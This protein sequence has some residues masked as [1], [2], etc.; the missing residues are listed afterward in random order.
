MFKNYS[1]ICYV[2]YNCPGKDFAHKLPEYIVNVNNVQIMNQFFF[3]LISSD[4][5]SSV[6]NCALH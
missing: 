4:E 5:S 3:A 1:I 6:N 2:F